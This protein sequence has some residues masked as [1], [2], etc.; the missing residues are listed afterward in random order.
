[1]ALE[2]SAANRA[3]IVQLIKRLR[4][5]SAGKF[6]DSTAVETLARIFGHSCGF[7][8]GCPGTFQE[9]MRDEPFATLLTV[10]ICPDVVA[11]ALAPDVPPVIPGGL[12]FPGTNDFG[13]LAGTTITNT[14]ATVIDGDLGLSPGTSVTGFP[15]GTVTGAQHVTDTDAAIAQVA[16]TAQ[17]LYLAGLPG[18]VIPAELGATTVTPGTWTSA[19]PFQISTGDLTLDAQGDP[20]AVFVFQSASTL[21][22]SNNLDVVL[23]NGA[24]AKNIYWQVGSSATLGNSSVFQGTIVALTS[25]TVG[26][27]AIVNGRVLARNGAVTFDDNA[28]NVPS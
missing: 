5:G 19:A 17:Y 7:R 24:Q 6:I 28:V 11:V 16:L 13:V 8:C 20:N 21:V 4:A 2:I 23:L 12:Q 27:S 15:P 1:M 22:T 9:G 14:G 26:A 18:T 25:I 3:K 10:M